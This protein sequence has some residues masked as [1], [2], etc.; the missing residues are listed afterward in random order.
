MYEIKRVTAR[1]MLD[2]ANELFAEHWGEIALNKQVM[3][4]KPDAERYLAIES[5]GGLI[6]LAAFHGPD[7]IGYSVSFVMP[8]LHYADLHVASNDI[9]FVTKAHR[10]SR[11][12]MQL[13][14]A[15]EKAAKEAGA[16]LMLWHAKP[17]TTLNALMP[18]L[19]YG[20]QDIIY[21]RE[22]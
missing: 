17:N 19:N 8:H 15:T 10:S 9:L 13:I 3:I 7:L 20:V 6:A 12:G 1:D 11:A 22:I 21:S 4:L 16:R 14:R 18:R 5:A 2:N